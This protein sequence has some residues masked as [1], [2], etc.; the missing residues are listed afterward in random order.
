MKC[1]GSDAQRR[2]ERQTG[3]EQEVQTNRTSGLSLLPWQSKQDDML[4]TGFVKKTITIPG[5]DDRRLVPADLR[6]AQKGKQ[7]MH[8]SKPIMTWRSFSNQFPSFYSKC[9]LFALLFKS[10]R[11]P[12]K[13][14]VSSLHSKEIADVACFSQR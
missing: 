11:R 2:Q 3:A 5:R 14:N 8:S 4:G 10:T 13:E 9:D 1:P 7:N 6:I 12:R